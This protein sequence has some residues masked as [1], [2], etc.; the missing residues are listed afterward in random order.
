[1][2]DAHRSRE[3]VPREGGGLQ[4]REYMAMTLGPVAWSAIGLLL[5]LPV[6]V[7][8]QL[9]RKWAQAARIGELPPQL[10]ESSG[11]AAS[12]AFPDRLYHI[13]DS[14]DAGRFYLTGMDG[15]G[16]QSVRITDFRPIDTEALSL[17]PCP[18]GLRHSCVYVGDIG[19]NRRRRKTIEI[20][21]VEEV[22]SFPE[23][24]KAA[25]RLTL[26]YP[27]GPH[28]A[29]SMAV[30][31]DGTL[32]ILTKE[33]PARLFKAR[34][35]QTEQTLEMVTTLATGNVPTD[36]A[37]SDDGK[38]VIVLTY[39]EAV[40]L[41]IDFKEQQKIPFVHLRHG[42]RACQAVPTDH[43]D[44]LQHDEV[45]VTVLSA[46]IQRNP[47]VMCRPTGSRRPTCPNSTPHGLQV[48]R[49]NPA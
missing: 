18:G 43:E 35:N 39:Q 3:L 40:E 13:N 21:V 45:G 16:P 15:S 4:F 5:L 14:G 31:P 48:D 25:A 6:S 20:A 17:G 7:D 46:R 37:I 19:D 22:R 12:S 44:G 9:C 10:R 27:D 2:G 36:M 41:G 11:I 49:K 23:A 34:L 32:F 1:M 29:E 33:R 47:A 26:R 24:I 42:A 8:A 30:H 28:D 38:R